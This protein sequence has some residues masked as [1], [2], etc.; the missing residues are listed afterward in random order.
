MIIANYKPIGKG[1]LLVAFDLDTPAGFKFTGTLLMEKD[2]R[3]WISFPGIPYD[4]NGKKGYKPVVEIPDRG[5]RD[6]FNE[7]VLEALRAG[8]FIQ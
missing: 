7:Q 2:G 5:R 8:G 1:S 6:K 4:S 3:M